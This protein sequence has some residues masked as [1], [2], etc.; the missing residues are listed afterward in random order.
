MSVERYRYLLFYA[1]SGAMTWVAHL[2]MMRTFERALLRAAIPVAWSGGFNPRPD[3]VFALPVG[4]GVET[5]HEPFQLTLTEAVKPEAL[6]NA[7]NAVLPPGLIIREAVVDSSVG[8][9]MARVTAATYTIVGA[10][11][12]S[13]VPALQATAP[14][15]VEKHSKKGLRTVD[16]RPGIIAFQFNGEDAL[17][18]SVRAGSNDN[19]RLDLLLDA[20]SVN[21]AKT[22]FNWREADLIRT[23]VVLN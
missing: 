23:E 21:V 2:D 8:S 6:V 9:I 5:R 14:L 20:L 19:V 15:N 17:Q 11:V 4:V 12:A 10:G 18:I 7:L 3:L 13:L 1:R 22:T 16:L